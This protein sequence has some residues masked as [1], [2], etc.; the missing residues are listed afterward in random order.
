MIPYTPYVFSISLTTYVLTLI[1]TLVACAV[2]LALAEAAARRHLGAVTAH[3][4]LTP[5]VDHVLRGRLMHSR[6]VKMMRRLHVSP[7]DYLHRVPAEEIRAQVETCTAC[8]HQFLCDAA[9]AVGRTERQ[10]LSF[11]PNR[12][13]L[14]ALTPAA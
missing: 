8:P 3:H 1:A 5:G 10:D 9:L 14:L 13:A 12:S 2:Y 4:P 6:L 7:A 11:C